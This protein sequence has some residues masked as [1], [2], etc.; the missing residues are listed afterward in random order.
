MDKTVTDGWNERPTRLDSVEHMDSGY[1][2]DIQVHRTVVISEKF[3]L[4]AEDKDHAKE[5]VQHYLRPLPLNS[6]LLDEEY[7]IYLNEIES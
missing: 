5:L 6:E 1:W 2:C 4:F 7:E 3:R